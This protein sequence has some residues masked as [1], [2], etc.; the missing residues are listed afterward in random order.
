[1][2]DD[3]GLN[4]VERYKTLK[5][6]NKGSFIIQSVIFLFLAVLCLVVPV[7]VIVAADNPPENSL[8]YEECTFKKY[9]CV[10]TRAGKSTSHRYYIYVKEYDKPLEIDNI[11]FDRT[12]ESDLSELKSG[13]KLTVSISESNDR[14]ELYSLSCD[15]GYILSYSNYLEAHKANERLGITT[16][17]LF[18]LV[19]LVAFIKGISHYKK[20]GRCL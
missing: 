12:Y 14:I 8:V 15:D 5:K 4:M 10:D 6:L 1:M 9:E 16:L 3:K 20:T 2:G 13:D 17:P 11:V 19:C 7:G 18:S